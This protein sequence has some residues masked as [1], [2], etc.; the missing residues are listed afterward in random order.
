MY[1]ADTPPRGLDTAAHVHL[2]LTTIAKR[3][4][5]LPSMDCPDAENALADAAAALADAITLIV[6]ADRLAAANDALTITH[7][8]CAI[9]AN[10]HN[11]GTP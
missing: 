6:T 1:L 10:S 5:A 11:T 4:D 7:A 9:R 8:V 2:A 3:L